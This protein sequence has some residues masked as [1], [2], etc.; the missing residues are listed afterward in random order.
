MS[1]TYYLSYALQTISS[2]QSDV[3]VTL[4][5]CFDS[6]NVPCCTSEVG[7]QHSEMVGVILKACQGETFCRHSKQGM[8][9]SMS[10]GKTDSWGPLSYWFMQGLLEISR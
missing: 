8:V 2:W 6:F 3:I 5:N 9:L 4:P 7:C 10:S 1:K